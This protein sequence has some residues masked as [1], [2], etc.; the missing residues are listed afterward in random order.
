ED[1]P[2]VMSNNVYMFDWRALKRWGLKESNLPPGSVVLNRQATFWELYKW[3]VISGISLIV[4]QALLIFGLLCQRARRAKA[5]GELR[6][7]E[8]R[9]RSVA[10]TA[11]VLI[12]MS[13]TD[14]LCTYVNQPW[15]DFTGR[16]IE[17]ELGNGRTDGIHPD[18]L[19]RCL[20]TYTQ[21][22]DRRE[23]VRMEYRVRRYDGEYRWVL[24][25]GVPRFQGSSFA[26]YIGCALDVSERKSMEKAVRESEERLRLAAQAGRMFAYS[27]DADT[28]VIERSGES[29][30]ILGIET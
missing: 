26:G 16:S 13:D 12:W 11:P 22:F 24:D 20:D 4:F 30:E 25:V 5:E 17:Q 29:A 6:E 9:F 19:Q 1:I 27:W 21:C 10:D 14:R 7:S 23:K 28:D 3:Y 18:D 2:I 15:L 8:A